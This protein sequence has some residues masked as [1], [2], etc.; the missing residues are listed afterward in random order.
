MNTSASLSFL[1]PW[2]QAESRPCRNKNFKQ[3]LLVDEAIPC[4]T[5]KSTTAA[6]AFLKLHPASAFPTQGKAFILLTPRCA[7]AFL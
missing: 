7:K 2:A 6:L 4:N 1:G 3:A 5:F